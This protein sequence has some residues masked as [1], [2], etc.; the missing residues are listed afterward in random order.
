MILLKGINDINN[1]DDY[2]YQGENF[3]VYFFFLRIYWN[4]CYQSL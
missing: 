4:F 3:D 2:F 1:G